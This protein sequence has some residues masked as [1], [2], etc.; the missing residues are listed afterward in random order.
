MRN[1]KIEYLNF[2]ILNQNVQNNLRYLSMVFSIKENLMI[3]FLG[4]VYSFIRFDYILQILYKEIFIYYLFKEK[5]FFFISEF[6]FINDLKFSS[7]FINFFFKFF[8]FLKTF[9]LLEDNSKNVF[10]LFS[11]SYFNSEVFIEGNNTYSVFSLWFDFNIL[12][13]NI[14]LLNNTNK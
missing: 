4:Y 9:F 11:K 3:D 14:K 6:C 5:L 12:G 7:I 10:V 1:L 2:L 8:K 13:S